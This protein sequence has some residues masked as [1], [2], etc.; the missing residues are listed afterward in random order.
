MCEG[1]AS[2]TRMRW[3][4]SKRRHEAFAWYTL[5][6][7]TTSRPEARYGDMRS[8]WQ[9]AGLGNRPPRRDPPLDLQS[10]GGSL[11]LSLVGVIGKSLVTGLVYLHEQLQTYATRCRGEMIA[12][13]SGSHLSVESNLRVFER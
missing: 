6:K 7:F 12:L 1:L 4:A 2:R 9:P 3:M 8:R 11:I 10:A 13:G 5:L